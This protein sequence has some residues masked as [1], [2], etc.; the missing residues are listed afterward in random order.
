M[1]LYRRKVYTLEAIEWTGENLEAI[2]HEICDGIVRQ[3]VDEIPMLVVPTG[4][5]EM[6][7][8]IGDFIV[9]DHARLNHVFVCGAAAFHSLYERVPRSM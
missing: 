2:R 4:R 8:R 5:G 7:A 6:R 1:P 3:D 9:K